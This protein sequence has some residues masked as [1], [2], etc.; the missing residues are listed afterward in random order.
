MSRCIIYHSHSGA[1]RRIA[2]KL[3]VACGGDL[4]EVMPRKKYNA[5]TL[6]LLGGYRALK[7]AEDPIEQKKIDVARYDMI[8]LGS[9]VWAGKPTPAINAAIAALRGCEGKTAIIFAT[10]KSNPGQT[11]GI[12]RKRLET[13]GIKVI[14]VFVFTQA[15]RKDGKKLNELIVSVNASMTE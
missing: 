14:G 13:M 15:D 7:D 2:K 5:L 9:P 4:I 8:V 10:C 1:T 11:V 12:L 3:K 6:Y